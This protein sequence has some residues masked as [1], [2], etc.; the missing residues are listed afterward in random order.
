MRLFVAVRPPDDV[1]A[2]VEA[3][4]TSARRSMVG[5]KWTTPDQWHI[6]LQFLGQVPEEAVADV[7]HALET[8]SKVQPFPARLAGSGGFPKAARARVIWLGVGP[9]DDRVAELARSV[10]MAL[11]P[12]GLLPEERTY[13]PH[14]TLARLKVSGDVGPV[15]EALGTD[16]VGKAFVVNEV[17]LYESKVSRAGSRYEPVAIVPLEG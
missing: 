7:A 2:A 5:P 9:G 12:L 3:A 8:V 11:E 13:H 10:N 6:T 4:L 1:L 16:P 15:I 17:V 14:L